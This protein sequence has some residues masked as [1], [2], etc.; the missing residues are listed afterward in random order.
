M[1]L[2]LW[3]ALNYHEALIF[4]R[5]STK[6]N[7][8]WSM[9]VFYTKF[10]LCEYAI[11]VLIKGQSTP[12]KAMNTKSITSVVKSCMRGGTSSMC[13]ALVSRNVVTLVTDSSPTLIGA[14]LTSKGHF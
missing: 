4:L 10:V 11:Y 2:H 14:G 9:Y 13:K 3:N 5:H 7:Q 8:W 12:I 6:I 1:H